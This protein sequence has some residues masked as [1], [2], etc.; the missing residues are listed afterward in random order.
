MTT[1]TL[2]RCAAVGLLALSALAVRHPAS[3]AQTTPAPVRRE[4]PP[5]LAAGTIAPDFTAT[6]LDGHTVKLSDYKGKIVVL[7]FWATWCPPCRASMPH[8]EKVYQAVKSQNIEVLGVCVSDT[9]ENF[10]KWIPEHKTD[11]TFDFAF[12]PAGRTGPNKI[13][14]TLY[15]VSGIP[16]TYIIGKDGKVVASVVGYDTG[17]KRV[18]DAL[19]KAGVVLPEEKAAEPAAKKAASR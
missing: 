13:S 15:K 5:L 9:R 18:E 3:Q 2:F 7:D 12:D 11:Y 17:D 4:R 8:L 14:S 10:D 6:A 1:R 19:K 16:T